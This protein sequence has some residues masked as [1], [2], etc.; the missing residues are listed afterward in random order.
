MAVTDNTTIDTQGKEL[1]ITRAFDA[2]RE[3]VW[4]AWADPDCLKQWWGPRDFTAPSITLDFREGGTYLYCMRSPE[5]QDYW[6]TGTFR[7]V[8]PMERIVYTDSFADA[9]GNPVPASHYGMEGDWP[10]ELRVT[11]TFEDQ[12]GKTKFMLRHAGL[13]E[14]QHREMCGMGWKESLD[15]L[16]AS[17]A[18]A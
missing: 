2:P 11:L 15:K 4:K 14:G 16:A 17:L 10:A 9:E 3:R 8:V 7:E 5:G 6:S 12:D 1:I 18:Q 13:P